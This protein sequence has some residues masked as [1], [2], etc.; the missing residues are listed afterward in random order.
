MFGSGFA[1]PT[2]GGGL[3]FGQTAPAAQGQGG[4]FAQP[5]STAGQGLFSQPGAAPAAAGG[6]FPGLS[7]GQGQGSTRP[8]GPPGEADKILYEFLTHAKTAGGLRDNRDVIFDDIEREVR[9][10][11]RIQCSTSGPLPPSPIRK[12]EPSAERL[13]LNNPDYWKLYWE[14]HIWPW[15]PE[16]RFYAPFRNFYEPHVSNV[17]LVHV[18]RVAGPPAQNEHFQRFQAVTKDEWE[19]YYE[20]DSSPEYHAG[21]KYRLMPCG[22]FGFEELQKRLIKQ[23]EAIKIFRSSASALMPVIKAAQEKQK[24]AVLRLKAERERQVL[25]LDRLL[26]LGSRVAAAIASSTRQPETPLENELRARLVALRDDLFLRQ[27]LEA[28]LRDIWEK[29]L[30]RLELQNL[31]EM[32]TDSGGAGV[33]ADPPQLSPDSHKLLREATLMLR[34]EA[35]KLREGIDVMKRDVGVAEREISYARGRDFRRSANAQVDRSFK[36]LLAGEYLDET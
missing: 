17:S 9:R 14:K 3:L 35:R 23:D 27:N 10:L 1:P 16:Y 4:F 34:D 28:R 11:L 33:G 20:N 15:S 31:T 12:W 36:T 32:D 24:T 6:L 22:I 13:D 8:D 5:P 2:G 30:M 25:L 18:G 7:V 21:T 26:K 29:N 19:R